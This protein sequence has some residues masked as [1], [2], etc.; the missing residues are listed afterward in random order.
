MKNINKY[1]GYYRNKR[2]TI[3]RVK[4]GRFSIIKL[5]KNFFNTQPIIKRY[6]NIG[7]K[8]L[9]N[10]IKEGNLI[11]IPDEELFTELL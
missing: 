11:K 8:K 1:N 10:D 4:N 7:N 2:G 9:F 6:Y 5:D 3:I